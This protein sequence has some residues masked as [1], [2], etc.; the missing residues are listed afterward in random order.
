MQDWL[1][2]LLLHKDGAEILI[3][4]AHTKI[5]AF[6]VLQC[7]PYGAERH[8]LERGNGQ[9][10]YFQ[11]ISKGRVA[12][13]MPVQKHFPALECLRQE[14]RVFKGARHDMHHGPHSL[15]RLSRIF[16]FWL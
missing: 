7:G 3:R 6:A 15:G 1:L 14:A 16:E 10:N 4:Y 13:A 2:L 11:C 8:H 9:P 5:Y 12:M